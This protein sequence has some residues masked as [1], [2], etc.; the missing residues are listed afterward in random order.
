MIME[1][2]DHS[3]DVF[4]DDEELEASFSESERPLCAVGS[5]AAM[6]ANLNQIS[7]GYIHRYADDN[8]SL[9]VNFG[10]GGSC[11]L[12][13]VSSISCQNVTQEDLDSLD[14]DS[15]TAAQ[16][17]LDSNSERSDSP[18]DF[19]N[20]KD[21]IEEAE[22]SNCLEAE[23]RMK[24][25]EHQPSALGPSV[26]QEDDFSH[27]F[28]D[29]TDTGTMKRR[30][31]E[32]D[33][34]IEKDLP[35]SERVE[36]SDCLSSDDLGW[37]LNRDNQALLSKISDYVADNAFHN[38]VTVG[39]HRDDENEEGPYRYS[40]PVGL[41]LNGLSGGYHLS[42]SNGRGAGD[43]CY[44]TLEFNKLLGERALPKMKKSPGVARRVGDLCVHPLLSNGK[45]INTDENKAES[46]SDVQ[47][48]E[49][50]VSIT[51]V[52]EDIVPP[53]GA[54][55]LE[56]SETEKPCKLS[57]LL[58]SLKS[59]KPPE[60]GI[61]VDAK[62][63]SN[64]VSETEV[65]DYVK[66]PEK[67]RE[68]NASYAAHDDLLAE[69]VH[70][71]SENR[72]SSAT[73]TVSG[74][75]KVSEEMLTEISL[76]GSDHQTG[77]CKTFSLSPEATDC[78]SADIAS[79]LSEDVNGM[80]FVEDGLSSSQC[81]DTDD[82]PKHARRV[83]SSD[84]RVPD[85]D[86]QQSTGEAFSLSALKNSTGQT[87]ILKVDECKTG[88]AAKELRIG[89]SVSHGRKKPVVMSPSSVIDEEEDYSEAVN[90]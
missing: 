23:L 75:T 53:N 56:P 33:D 83:V 82:T 46:T 72:A 44:V 26:V 21:D 67:T 19:D 86:R 27:H 41:T 50:I 24:V 49:S 1:K 81:S 3:S 34:P 57:L 39:P 62:L 88:K 73:P 77:D 71:A 87:D 5:F 22:F 7:D 11:Q 29:S 20:D 55:H 47:V 2:D 40:P 89:S 43:N 60:G 84:C 28:D 31:R 6:L 58:D 76:N 45:D 90:K 78:D 9:E 61:A 13:D 14:C 66:S 12:S 32:T 69:L 37:L 42:K 59:K 38:V 63:L 8:F 48:R 18:V 25:A 30:F 36:N 15:G 79:V 10:D 54:N 52:L 17:S 51:N 85:I 64:G 74:S 4:P 16:N 68:S 80:P 65:S 35:Q 70:Q